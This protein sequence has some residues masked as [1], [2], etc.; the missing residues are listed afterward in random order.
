M[1]VT[2]GLSGVQKM[3]REAALITSV[4]SL[5]SPT[6]FWPRVQGE[7]WIRTDSVFFGWRKREDFFGG[8]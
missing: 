3:G 6:K 2:T 4:G 7:A 8:G 5:A 1:Q